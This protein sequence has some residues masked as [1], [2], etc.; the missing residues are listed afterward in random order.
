ML[1]ASI[2]YE[3]DHTGRWLDHATEMKSFARIPLESLRMLVERASSGTYGLA[4]V[5]RIWST[6]NS[7]RTAPA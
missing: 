4:E 6:A 7:L 3:V 5:K 1:S 2:E